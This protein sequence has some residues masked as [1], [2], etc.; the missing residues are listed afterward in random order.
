MLSMMLGLD[1][2]AFPTFIE[3]RK[4]TLAAFYKS[5]LRP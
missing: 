4:R 2:A 3:E 1:D 5:A